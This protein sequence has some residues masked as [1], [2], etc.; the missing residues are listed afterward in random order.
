[1]LI[2]VAIF[3]VLLWRSAESLSKAGRLQAHAESASKRLGE[4]RQLALDAAG[5]GWWHYDPA[6]D[7][8]T[9]DQRFR[10]I[11]GLPASEQASV[12]LLSKV[13]PDDINR[14]KAAGQAF[15]QQADPKPFSVEHRIVRADGSVR[16]IQAH[17]VIVFDLVDG[18]R[19]DLHLVGTVHDVT[20]RK[21]VEQV[22]RDSEQRYRLLFDRNPDGVFV[23][24]TSGRFTLVN[25][26]CEEISG[27]TSSELLQKNFMELCAPD[28]LEKTIEQFQGNLHQAKYAQLE[29]AMVRKDGSRVELWIT[30]EP[31]VHEGKVVAL[32]CT[33]R[34]V[35]ERKRFLSAL[36]ESEEQFRT[37]ADSIPNLAWWADAQGNLVWSNRR[38]YEYTGTTPEQMKGWGWQTVH[39]PAMLPAVVERWK[40]SIASSP[41]L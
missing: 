23:A 35:T 37:L 10:E 29:T 27:Y 34:D 21:E 31:I 7:T 11:F 25:P 22:L 19:R 14:V 4:Q 5:L 13:H 36:Q 26:A 3:S 15:M 8:G 6:T 32:H 20:E 16:W 18:N 40:A 41:A 24:D 33:A 28:Q 30:G 38:W 12:G 2:L 1:M 39:D 9:G 17:A